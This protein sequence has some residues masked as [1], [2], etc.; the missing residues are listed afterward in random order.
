MGAFA[1]Q[2]L[3][4]VLE[5]GNPVSGLFAYLDPGT[6]SFLLQMLIGGLLA[7]MF[8]MKQ[9]WTQIKLSFMRGDNKNA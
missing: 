4:P 6:G 9:Y 5:A 3:S 1:V 2:L 8:T 7:G